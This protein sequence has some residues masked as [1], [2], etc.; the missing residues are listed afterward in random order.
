MEGDVIMA[1][2]DKETLMYRL[3]ER[4]GN[5]ES[6]EAIS[7]IEDVSDTFDS[8]FCVSGDSEDW[9]TKYEENDAAWRKK[10]RDRFFGTGEE[11]KEEQEEDVK[12]D[13][14]VKTFDELFEEREG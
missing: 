12:D 1:V 11:A 3:K 5:D 14:E 9:K 10:Y 6:D 13:S 7:F 8:L 4:F 2:L